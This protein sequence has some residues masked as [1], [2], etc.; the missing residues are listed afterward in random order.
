MSQPRVELLYF[1]GCPNQEAARALVER[2]ATELAI[3]A[4]MDLVEIANANA[5]VQLRFLGSPTVRVDG[6]DVEP[7]AEERPDF[8]LA[9]R[10]YRTDEGLAGQPDPA[11]IRDALTRSQK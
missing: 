2:I 10:V 3:E 8:S 11:W 5:A 9:C 6:L 4:D 7:G 1:D